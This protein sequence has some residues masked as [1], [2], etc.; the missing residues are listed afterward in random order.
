[1]PIKKEEYE[2]VKDKIAL[3]FDIVYDMNKWSTPI[4]ELA[5]KDWIKTC[6]WLDMLINQAV[7]WFELWSDWEKLDVKEL[8]KMLR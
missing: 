2:K 8:E 6:E 3:L 5:Q 4:I 7:K 1:M